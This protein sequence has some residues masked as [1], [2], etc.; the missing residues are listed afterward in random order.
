MNEAQRDV[1][2]FRYSLIRE[3]ADE[4]LTIRQRGR[5]VR[6][7]A[8][9][10]HAGPNG[11]ARP[12]GA[13]D[14]RPLDP[15]LS[16]PAASRR[17]RPVPRTGEP[18]TE[19]R[20][21]DLAEAL[22]RE[23]PRR[24]AAQVAQIIRTAEGCGPV[25][26]HAAA[27]LRPPRAQHPPRRIAARGLRPLRGRRSGR[28]V[29]RRRP[30]RPGHRRAQDLPVRLHRRPLPGAGRL[31]L[32]ALRGHRPPRG[33][34][35]RRARVTRRARAG[36]TS[37]T[38]RAI[39]L[40]AAAAGAAPASAIR[41]V[42][43]KP[44]R[45]QGRGKIE[46]VFETVRIQFLVEVE[47]R[48]PADLAE[49]NR[50]FSAWVETVYHRR[51]HSETGEAPIERLLAGGPPVLPTPAALHEAFLWSETRTVTK[52]ATVSLHGN[53]FEVDAALVG[54]ARRGRLRPLRPGDRRDPLP[55][56]VHG[57]GRPGQSIGRHSHPQAR[58]EAAPAPAPTGIDYLGLLAER[59]EAELARSI[60]Y[61]QLSLRRRAEPTDHRRHHRHQRRQGDPAMTIDRLRA[62][63]GF[64][65]MPFAKD[66]APSM[67]HT[68]RSHAEAVG[69]DHL[70]HRRAGDRSGHRRGRRRQDR[71]GARPRWPA[72]TPAATPSSTSATR[73]SGRGAC[74]RDRVDARRDPRFHRASLIPQAQD[75]LAT[76]EHERGRRVVLV[77]DEAHLLDA[78]Q[79]EGLRLSDQR[80][81][82]QPRALR[83]PA[84]R[85]AD[86]A[87]ADPPRRLRRP[88]PARGAALLDDRAWSRPRRPTTSPTT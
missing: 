42:H 70:V 69:P 11:P 64:T 18:V 35:P 40:Q 43:S 71:G 14:D 22:K 24:T 49:L 9:R 39:R 31:S 87:P 36:A 66:L 50:L 82:G 57:P 52:T 10:D 33:G 81:D 67:L 13:R 63:W 68:H 59:R 51:V 20:L 75:A 73:R 72:S 17:W 44:G 41:L 5:L 30:A 78:E 15:G 8:G 79:L 62:H 2:L 77:L 29:D 3:A 83:L 56:P 26:A 60:N 45:P 80:R 28:P 85:P 23:V 32:G 6:E 27:A 54:L 86:A 21:L 37:T 16:L 53:T 48:P 55:G 19:K 84:R 76:E 58:P 65:R 61:A 4:S 38:A 88:R 46:R 47:A 34:V 1:A 12:G 74:T 25:G 7:L